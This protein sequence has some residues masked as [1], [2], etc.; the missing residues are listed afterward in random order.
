MNAATTEKI[1]VYKLRFAPDRYVEI[2]PDLP[3]KDY[4]QMMLLGAVYV[5]TPEQ[6]HLLGQ[7]IQDVADDMMGQTP[8]DRAMKCHISENMDKALGGTLYDNLADSANIN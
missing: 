5:A 7:M 6:L 1:T 4:P 2:R 3:T 8:T